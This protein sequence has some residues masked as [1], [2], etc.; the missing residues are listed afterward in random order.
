[1]KLTKSLFI[2]PALLAFIGLAST[3]SYAV[4]TPEKV[5]GVKTITAEELQKIQ[6]G[7]GTIIDARI[8]S[9]YADSHITGSVNIPYR[10][11]SAKAIDFDSAQDE[12]DIAKLP[13]DKNHPIVTY[14]NGIYCWKSPKAA[15]LAVRAGYKNV[16]WYRVGFDD[17]KAKNLPKE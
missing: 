12:F 2:V 3:P 9:E 13:A 4:D 16:N 7:G 11:K 1:M 6:A 5:E 15:I 10:E 17:W 14:C 8:A